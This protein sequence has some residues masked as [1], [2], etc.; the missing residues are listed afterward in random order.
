MQLCIN[1][2]KFRLR[3][4]FH[5]NLYA[6]PAVLLYNGLM[7]TIFVGC[8]LLTLAAAASSQEYRIEA[9]Q[10]IDSGYT[11]DI[12]DV[13]DSGQI[14]GSRRAD[15][16]FW[17]AAFLYDHGQVIRLAEPREYGNSTVL[18]LS[19]NGR[20]LVGLSDTGGVPL[21]GAQTYYSGTTVEHEDFGSWDGGLNDVGL[22]VGQDGGDGEGG[23]IPVPSYWTGENS[24]RIEGYI[25]GVA[26]DVNNRNVI[27]GFLGDWPNYTPVYWDEQRRRHE[28]AKG[29]IEL[30]SPSQLTDSGF[31]IGGSYD[32][33]QRTG[34]GTFWPEFGAEPAFYSHQE[35]G[36]TNF[37]DIAEDG[38]IIGTWFRGYESD[39]F[40][41]EHG[42]TYDLEDVSDADQQ[43]WSQLY[44]SAI[45]PSGIIAGIGFKDGVTQ[46]FLA[47]P[48]PE[49]STL[50]LMLGGLG[51]FL[52][53]RG[54]R[55]DAASARLTVDS[56]KRHP[57]RSMES[58]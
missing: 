25:R 45:S 14:V 20:V 27:V 54:V 28:L 30:V 15:G 31:T 2:A 44:V 24:T 18:E 13:N 29:G 42:A 52:R 4:L 38:K 50:V 34:M 39:S 8:L 9:V 53:R 32:P 56:L 47:T 12:T 37:R 19:A 21:Y 3:A 33:V 58:P 49:P 23:T 55:R 57:Q 6:E 16:S 51:I 43:G 1:P 35:T 46:V 48:V 26:T 22:V 17:T 41:Y 36:S 11:Y 5:H 7:K 40:I 10:G